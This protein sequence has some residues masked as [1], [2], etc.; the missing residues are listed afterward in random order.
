MLFMF[1]GSPHSKYTTYLLEF[2]TDL[3]LESGPELKAAKLDS[4][5]VNLTGEAGRF[6]AKDF[7]QERGNRIQATIAQ[8]KGREY[9]GT[10]MRHVT[11]RK[12]H[13]LS[14]IL[15]DIRDSSALG[16]RPGKHH[17]PHTRPEI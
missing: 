7:V 15:D 17:K 3:E 8:R 5:L 1:A 13:R 4:L 2:I 16:K 6:L 14:C 12:L 9:G 10:F 11:S